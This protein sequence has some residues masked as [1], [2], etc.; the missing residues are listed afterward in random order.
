MVADFGRGG[1]RLR[2]VDVGGFEALRFEERA[3]GTLVVAPGVKA[4]LEGV[5]ADDLGPDDFLFG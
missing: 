5:N 1:D 3:A 4:L 2:F